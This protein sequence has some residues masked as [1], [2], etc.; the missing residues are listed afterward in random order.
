MVTASDH[1]L[2]LRAR[3]GD[4]EAFG[5]LVRRYQTSVFNVCY[6]LLGERREAEDLAQEAFIRAYQRFALYDPNRPFGPWMRRVAANLCLNHMQI[7]SIAHMSIDDE[8]DEPAIPGHA[9]PEKLQ[10][11]AESLAALRMALLSLPAHYRA[12]VELRHFQEMSYAEIAHWLKI[13]LSDVKSH[14]FRARQLL[15]K[16]LKAYG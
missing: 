6:R 16:K 3:N 11:Q 13:P 12:V 2:A 8:R 9:S 4:T 14:L 15:A 5:E 1:E 10:E 7:N